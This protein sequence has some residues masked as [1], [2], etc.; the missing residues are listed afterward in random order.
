[1]PASTTPS[2]DYIIGIDLGTTNSC[3]GVEKDGRFE[4]IANSQGERT[5][6]S[7]VA[8]T[9]DGERLIGQAAKS[10]IVSNVKRTIYDIKRI[11]GRK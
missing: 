1:M 3:V 9:E 4:I 7:V 11:I 2:D 6:P 10:Q 8:F 5:T